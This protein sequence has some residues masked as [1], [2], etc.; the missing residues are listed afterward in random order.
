M[1]MAI[2]GAR[3]T[4]TVN[5]IAMI[6]P[7]IVAKS[8]ICPDAA[9]SLVGCKIQKFLATTKKIINPFLS[10]LFISNCLNLV[11]ESAFSEDV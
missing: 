6:A 3:A 4:N 10:L 8:Q 5:N 7:G 1:N 2:R 11:E 9:S